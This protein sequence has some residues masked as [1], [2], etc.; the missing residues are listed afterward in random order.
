M[1]RLILN[2]LI[3]ILVFDV[4]VF[5]AY[6]TSAVY[7]CSAEYRSSIY[8]ERLMNVN[9]TGDY[10]TD[11]I[12][13]A[14]S[15]VGYRE[16]CC[17]ADLSGWNDGSHSYNNYC[18]YNYWYYD[19]AN[20]G[21][22]NY[23]WCAV[24]VSWCA[25][26]AKIPTSILKNSAHAGHS[27]SYFN[28]PYYSGSSYTPKPGDLFF[29]SSWS[30]V[31]IVESVS[32]DSFTTIEGNTNESGSSTGKGVYNRTRYRLADY[33]FGVPNYPLAPPTITRV[34]AISTSSLKVTWTN[35]TDAEK[36]EI[37]R[38]KSG[39][40]W[41]DAILVD[42]STSTFYTD[43][44]LK[45]GTKY[46]YRVVAVNGSLKSEQSDSNSSYTKPNTV[47]SVDFTDLTT[48]SLTVTW[49][50]ISSAISYDVYRR[51]SG[52]SWSGMGPIANVTA[53]SFEDSGLEAGEKYYYRIIAI[54]ESTKSEVSESF[55][56]YTKLNAPIIKS[57][58][59]ITPTSLRISW[60]KVDRATSYD[61]YRRKS[62]ESW[63]G[64][65][66]IANVKTNNFSDF[67]LLSGEMY[68]YRV[69]AR[70]EATSSVQSES[71]RVYT[72]YN[73]SYDAND[74]SGVLLSQSKI[75]DDS[76]N[77]SDII[78]SRDGYYFREWNTE[79]DGSGISYNPGDM[80]T[81]N[82]NLVLYAQWEKLIPYIKSTV[83]KSNLG[84]IIETKIENVSSTS[85]EI[86]IAGY[87]GDKFVTMK[88]VSC[89]EQNLPYTL[90]G[91]IDTIKIM[92]WSSLS[93][94]KP[95]CEAEIIPSSK[96]VIE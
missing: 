75:Y 14:K 73:I 33:Y 64:L 61:V 57:A 92:V 15:Q 59:E 44:G 70:N 7:T 96:F 78:P 83:T 68:Y 10:R 95:L 62:G 84:Y 23:D 34:S 71:F 79:A 42:T 5:P 49:D 86:L 88:K 81:E 82:K 94:L 87:K 35:V 37:Y 31:G 21:G 6:A 45:A 74:E 48:N 28:I 60:G 1:K 2:L 53:C 32:G 22:V 11:I 38:R 52:E 16:G 25:R 43:T 20:N 12:N 89:S 91:D 39:E 17:D 58:S 47:T 51:T 55:S 63:S 93:G 46:F 67:G 4:G 90:E 13:V 30:H 9:L 72:A 80:Y 36:Y 26:Q 54:N 18:E 77:L 56:V 65:K 85:Y 19:G 66:P 29:T 69:T 76:I 24:F 50:K 27:S 8:Y 41:N 40:S 3:M